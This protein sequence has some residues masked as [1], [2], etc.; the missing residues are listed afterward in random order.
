MEKI[1]LLLDKYQLLSAE[2][3]DLKRALVASIRKHTGLEILPTQIS[4]ARHGVYL[5]LSANLRSAIFVQRRKIEADVLRQTTYLRP[6][7][8]I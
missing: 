4:V 3:S 5:K 2:H 7:L 1:A 6:P 8:V